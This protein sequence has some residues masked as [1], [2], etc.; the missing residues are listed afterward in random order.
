MHTA[1]IHSARWNTSIPLAAMYAA[2]ATA[3]TVLVSFP[4]RSRT[5]STAQPR[6]RRAHAMTE[7][8]ATSESLRSSPRPRSDQAT[9]ADACPAPQATVRPTGRTH[10][11]TWSAN[12]VTTTGRNRAGRA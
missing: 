8:K 2:M 4:P 7:V 6:Q 9:V 3:S 1:S 5:A 11:R 10:Q 12:P